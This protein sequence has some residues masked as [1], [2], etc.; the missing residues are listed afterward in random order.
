MKKTL[1]KYDW[2]FFVPKGM[3]LRERFNAISTK[4]VTLLTGIVV[5]LVPYVLIG[6]VSEGIF[7]EF[8]YLI[9][10][11]MLMVITSVAWIFTKQTPF[12][13]KAKVTAIAWAILALTTALSNISGLNGVFY[14]S[15]EKISFGFLREFSPHRDGIPVKHL[16]PVSIMDDVMPM[17]LKA[18]AQTNQLSDEVDIVKVSVIDFFG[19]SWINPVTLKP[20][21]LIIAEVDD[22]TLLLGAVLNLNDKSRYVFGAFHKLDGDWQFFNLAHEG[23]EGNKGG[24][25][26]VKGFSKVYINKLPYLVEQINNQFKEA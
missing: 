9:D 6:R 7:T 15:P 16:Y 2:Q 26:V 4:I 17:E 25:Y 19:A 1:P 5:F 24:L 22:D 18:L 13:T 20:D 11:V 8:V 23:L 12:K 10:A 14:S 21:S 3:M